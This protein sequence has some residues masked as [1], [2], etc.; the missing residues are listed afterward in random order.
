M[1]IENLNI[2]GGNQQFADLIINSSPSLDETDRD[3]IQLIH[4]NVES[5]EGRKELLNSLE[6]L[7]AP[8]QPEEEKKKSG[9]LLKKFFDSIATEG[10]EQVVKE[11][12]KSGAEYLQYLI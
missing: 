10:G 5:D 2:R 12:A 9:S 7:K 8:E 6:T 1:K 4:E 11:F 3:I